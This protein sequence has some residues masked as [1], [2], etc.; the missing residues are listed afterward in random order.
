MTEVDFA[1]AFLLIISVITYSVVAV[2]DRLS[3]NFATYSEKRI[4]AAADSLSSQI[5]S[6]DGL[7]QRFDKIQLRIREIG[8]F[9]HVERVTF[10]LPGALKIHAY[11]ST[12]DEIES[13]VSAENVTIVRSLRSGQ[14]EYIDV[15]YE[16]NVSSI[17]V[18]AP[19]NVSVTVVFGGEIIALSYAKCQELKSMNYTDAKTRFGFNDYFSLSLCDYGPSPPNTNI[20]A[21]SMPLMYEDSDGTMRYAVSRL[22]VW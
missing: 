18:Y 1:I 3:S 9:D 19:A 6:E 14:S 8:N 15:I 13:T 2:S 12:M 10:G 20:V 17:S 16:G 21:R 4:E 22:R 11:N 5:F 7:M